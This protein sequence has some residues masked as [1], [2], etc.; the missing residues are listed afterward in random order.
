MKTP[1]YSHI[2]SHIR[3]Q[4]GDEGMWVIQT[5]DEHCRGVAS[6]AEGFSSVFGMGDW[7]RL[8]GLLHDRGKESDAF[9]CILYLSYF[10]FIITQCLLSLPELLSKDIF[11][12]ICLSILEILFLLIGSV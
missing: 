6:R 4:D 9:Q 2:M 5:N 7:G 3:R 11:P 10:I 1:R 12:M 8:M